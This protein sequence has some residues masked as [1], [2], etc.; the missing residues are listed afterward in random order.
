MQPSWQYVG[1]SKSSE[2]LLNRLNLAAFS[3]QSPVICC[4]LPT[5]TA[6]GDLQGAVLASLQ[7]IFHRTEQPKV[8]GYGLE[9][10]HM[11]SGFARFGCCLQQQLVVLKQTLRATSVIVIIVF[12]T[13]STA[14]VLTRGTHI[15]NRLHL[16]PNQDCGVASVSFMCSWWHSVACLR[17]TQL[18]RT[19]PVRCTV[20]VFRMSVAPLTAH[21]RSIRQLV[22]MLRNTVRNGFWRVSDVSS[23]L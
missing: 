12:P 1:R 10:L 16:D 5:L 13:E 14:S 7:C 21:C 20:R 11:H 2:L 15:N 3:N 23:P 22:G 19:S 8:I 4:V 9:G 6:C 18:T 17:H